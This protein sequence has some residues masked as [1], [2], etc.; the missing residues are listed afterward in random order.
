MADIL[1]YAETRGGALRPVAAEV[2]A[3][4]RTIADQMGGQ[5][6]A[7]VAGGPG[8]TGSAG[9]L[10]RF[11]ADRVLV[12]ESES[13]ALYQPDAAV[14][15]LASIA[16]E[17]S[18]GA[19]LFPASAQGKDLAARLAARL[20][21]PL[22]SEVTEVEVEDGV[23]VVTRPM[24]G[25]KAYGRFRFLES[26]ALISLRPNVFPATVNPRE[27]EIVDLP[28]SDVTARTRVVAVESAE[29]GALDV[30]EAP[31]VVAGG[32]GMGDPANWRLLEDLVAALGDDATLGA[33][34]AVV[35]AGWRPHSEQVGQTGKVVSP[36]LYFAVG[37]SGAIQHLAGMRTAGVI[38]AVNKDAEAPIFSVANYGVVGDLFEVLPRLTEEIR[39]VRTTGG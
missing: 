23:P 36:S 12:A 20:D 39:A 14:E 22:A 3:T 16:G 1:A 21:R 19:I 30:R 37:I 10:G 13:F 9:D 15:L 33:S 34:R 6:V 8:S 11:G 25:G 5:V 31:V 38:V 4:A 26:P 2:V 28:A 32:R 18:P 17:A 35:D 7:V 29:R 24:Y 27:S